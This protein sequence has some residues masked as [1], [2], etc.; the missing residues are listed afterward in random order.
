MA[1]SSP[2]YAIYPLLKTPE[3]FTAYAGAL[4]LRPYQVPPF[5]AII[6]SVVQGRGDSIVITFSRQSGK[7]ETLAQLLVYLL[8]IFDHKPASTIFV[9]PTFKP[10]T[11]GAMLRLESRLA[12]NP[13][14]RGRWKQRAGYIYQRGQATVTYF[15]AEPSASVVGATASHLLIVNEA[16]DVQPAVYDK[17]FAPMAAANNATRVF[18]GTAW[19]SDSLL[20]RE[21]AAAESAEKRERK[22]RRRVFTVDAEEVSETSEKYGQFLQAELQRLGRQHPLIKSQYFN[23][24]VDA[25]ASMFAPAVLAAIDDPA[26]AERAEP[27]RP[28]Y[29]EGGPSAFLIDVAGQSE[30][31]ND[32]ETMTNPAR[33]QT[34]LTIV[35]LDL[36][37]LPLLGAPTY[38]ITERHAWTGTNHLAIFGTLKALAQA[39]RPQYIL[40]DATGVGE[41]LWSL[42][43]SAFPGIV[44]PVKFSAA[45]KSD[46]GWRFLAI[47]GTG[48][49]RDHKHTPEVHEQYIRARSEILPGPAKLMRWGVP[50][51]TRA[52][53]AAALVHDDYLLADSLVAVLDELPWALSLPA[54]ILEQPDPLTEADHAY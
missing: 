22:S 16:Q 31:A 32:P 20:E 28:E 13:F 1:A 6:E 44:T 19:T 25:E 39:R 15:S 10:Q 52:G 53:P 21:R 8:T 33:D 34:T 46:I 17:R 30:A 12:Q 36:S 38:H 43:D 51:G 54:T 2:A 42:L 23:E 49:L 41:G 45:R 14:T 37:S 48:R 4:D 27:H 50:D 11:V 9:S 7:D 18:A 26:D 40:V 35:S 29:P 47:A 24:T 5:L 3:H